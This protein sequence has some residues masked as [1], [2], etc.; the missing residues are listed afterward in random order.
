ML[1]SKAL[2]S[3][4]GLWEEYEDDEQ[5]T[6][7]TFTIITTTA[8]AAISEIHERMPVILDEESEKTWLDPSKSTEEHLELLQPYREDL[9]SFHTI[10]PLVNKVSNDYPQLIVPTPPADQFGN[11]TL[12]D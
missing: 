10:S 1:S 8:N 6:I 12:F 5:Q 3:F 4:A 9:M 11:L 7:H 2:F